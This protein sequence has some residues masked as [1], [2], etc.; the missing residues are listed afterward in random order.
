MF[1]MAFPAFGAVI[2]CIIRGIKNRSVPT[3]IVLP[4]V[5]YQNISEACD[6]LSRVFGFRETYRHGDP[7][8]GVMMHLGPVFLMLHRA[9]EG[10]LNP[11]ELGYRTQMLT[12]LVKDVDAHYKRSVEAGARIVEELHETVYGER[13]Y[14]V[15]DIEGHKWLFSQHARD[16]DPAEWGAT[17]RKAP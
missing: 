3:D 10:C 16:A 12:I 7:V 14:G 1:C 5:S 11:V 2:F 8:S 9:R 6:W 17:L 4:H 13:Q 15:E